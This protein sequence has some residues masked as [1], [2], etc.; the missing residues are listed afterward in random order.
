MNRNS[1]VPLL[2]VVLAVACGRPGDDHTHEDGDQAHEGA[3]HAHGEAESWAVTAW[4][5]R[6]EIF[7][8][9]DA[10]VAG[11]V[12]SAHTHVTVLA[13]FVPLTSGAVT[14]VLRDAAGREER[15]R[16][17]QA[18][19]DG[20]FG[21]EIEPSAEGTYQLA[22][23][24]EA[25]DDREEI[26]AGRVRVGSSSSPGGLAEP[27]PEGGGGMSFLKEQ[28]WRTEF[29]TAW[30]EEGSLRESVSGPARVGP[31]RG[32]TVVLTASTDAVVAPEPWPYVGL[33]V[34]SGTAVFRLRPRASG[35]SVPELDAQ[36]SAL[37]AEAEAARKRVERL[38]ELLLLEATSA[39]ELERARAALAGTEARLEAA[40]RGL[41]VA[42]G[43]A[44][45][46]GG[47]A[48]PAP[49]AGRVAQVAV[50]PGQA[51]A[52][53]DVL[54]RLVRPRPVWVEVALRPEQAPRLR[55]GVEGLNLRRASLADALEIEAG[56]VR[57]IAVA[58]E[59]D[60]NTATL[61]ATLEVD[62]GAS[63]LPIGSAMEAE[64]IL[65]GERL[66]IVIPRSAVVDDAGVAI[67]YV[68]D[69]GERFSRREVGVL[70]RQGTRVLVEGLRAGE[71]VVTRG[72]ASIR[73]SSL[74]SSGAPEGHVH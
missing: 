23:V 52:A 40:R 67:A 21:V 13:G 46:G 19:R 16:Q 65:S 9:T 68:Q 36:A 32:G 45:A 18:L 7:S 72:G 6:Y 14:A 4:G 41:A 8:E 43:E 10:L 71:R 3:D 51:V 12:A 55:S 63:E 42:A 60:P 73:R 54:G 47:L 25:G 39:A 74:L 1:I 50:T 59:V 62:R 33:D 70:A 61:A 69:S 11:Q 34:G 48:V 44:P 64:I 49:W 2:A 35:S 15:F 17:E 31:S 27:E 5:E 53:G 28:Q 20:I 22:F 29:A 58:P 26:A 38:T 66:G 57:L 30:V 37:E 56:S 24:V